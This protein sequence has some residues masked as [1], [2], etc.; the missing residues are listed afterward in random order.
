MPNKKVE[1]KQIAITDAPPAPGTNVPRSHLVGLD[2]DG[3][4]WE[5]FAD[6]PGGQWFAIEPPDAP[7]ASGKRLGRKR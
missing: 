5:R 6:T 2:T 1:F 4:I 3:R 7:E